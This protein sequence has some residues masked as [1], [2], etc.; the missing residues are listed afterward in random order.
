MYRASTKRKVRGIWCLL[1]AVKEESKI[2]IKAIP[3]APNMGLG[4]KHTFITPVTKAV[5]LIIRI[6][7]AEPYRSSSKGPNNR[8]K[9]KLLSK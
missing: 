6:N 5:I 9:D 4:I 2:I 3:L 1:M 8:I 7:I